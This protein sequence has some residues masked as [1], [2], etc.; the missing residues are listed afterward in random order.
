MKRENRPQTPFSLK[1]RFGY[2]FDNKMTKGSLALIRVLIVASVLLAMLIA[3]LII[4]FG[5]NEDGETASV[6]WNSV[7]TVINAWMPNFEEGSVG[8]LILMSV[9]AIAGVLFTS[10]LIGIITSAIEEK[11]DSLKKGNSRVLERDHTVVLGFSPGEYSLINQLILAA[12]GKPAC[13]VIAEDMEREEMEQSISENVEAP[14]NFRIVCRT[15]DI[16][17]PASLEKCSLES[18]RTVIISPTDDLKTLKAILAV[19]ALLDEKGAPEI[20]VNAVI[21]SGEYRFPASLAQTNNIT[22][23]KTNTIVAKMIA[24]SCTQTGLSETFREV[25]DFEGCEFYSASVGGIEKMTFGELTLRLDRAVPAGIIRN[26]KTVLNPA[27]DTVLEE[28]DRILLFSEEADPAKTEMTEP[29]SI[30][31]PT[32]K[33][34]AVIDSKE[35]TVIFGH[36]ETLPVILRELPENVSA[37]YLACL[38]TTAEENEELRRIA[39][40]RDLELIFHQGNTSPEETLEELARIAKHV[41]ILNDHLRD[42]EEADME[43][44]LLLLNLRDIRERAGLEFNITVELRREQNHKLASRRD[45]TDFLVSSSMSSLILAQLAENPDLKDVFRELLS[46][47]GNELYL[48]NAGQMRLTG[49]HTVRELRA[50]MLDRGYV[51]LGHLDAEKNSRYN[52]PLDETLDIKEEDDLIVLGRN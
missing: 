19:T 2:W 11:I 12:A 33:Q 4:L 36:N 27:A 25:F 41:V 44:V 5:F 43:A 48:K 51:L 49:K 47:D 13:L 42:P 34:F 22:T 45:H 50:A 18:C 32:E 17:D 10:V 23:L 37:V 21:S 1:D 40:E 28:N 14:K 7:A 39:S 15:A 46:N 38:N 9:T 20:G 31:K 30:K 6:F 29:V 24:H 3:G 35:Y 26:S 8:Y 16:T 52:L